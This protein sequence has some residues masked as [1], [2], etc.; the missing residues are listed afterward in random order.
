MS[1]LGVMARGWW[2]RLDFTIADY[3]DQP[4]DVKREIAQI[5]TAIASSNR[6]GKCVDFIEFFL[7]LFLCA[8]PL[9]ANDFLSFHEDFSLLD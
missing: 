2:L 6:L 4:H 9:R 7:D 5:A 1:H 3:F 8:H